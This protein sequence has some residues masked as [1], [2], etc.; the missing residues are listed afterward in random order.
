MQKVSFL[1]DHLKSKIEKIIMNEFF[2]YIIGAEKIRKFDSVLKK[3]LYDF[4]SY[5]FHIKFRNQIVI[6]R[7][8]KIYFPKC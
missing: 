2:F 8:S 1:R 5:R 4:F 6:K 3:F 7:K